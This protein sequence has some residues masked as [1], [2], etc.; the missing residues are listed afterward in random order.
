MRVLLSTIGS[1]GDVEPMVALGRYLRECG[2][3]ALLCAPPGFDQHVGGLAYL[4]IGHDLRHGP[5]RVPG[6]AAATAAAH[7]A[8][9]G[10][11]AEGCDAIVGC[12]AM[13]IAGRSI[14][15]QRG[16]RYHY[17]AYAPVALPSMHHPPPPVGGPPRPAGLDHQSMW[18]LDAQW[19]N[20]TWLSGLNT[21]RGRLGLAP[22]DDVRGHILTARPLLA[23]DPTLAPCP[24]DI[25]TQV[26]QTGAWL[27]TDERPLDR[28]LQAFLDS[29]EPPVLFGF[30]SMREPRV[31]VPVLLGAAREVGR[32]AII[33]R[34]WAGL[35]VPDASP[36]HLSIGETN[37]PALLGRV[38]AIVHHGGAGTTTQ[39]MRAGVPQVIVAHYFDQPYHAERVTALGIG[40]AHPPGAVSIE[41]LAGALQSVLAD[42]VRARA[43]SMAG[44]VRTD[45]IAVAAREIVN[46]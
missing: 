25:A 44:T 27:A 19:W 31:G 39:A 7:F 22:V 9:I 11:A 13:Q 24:A 10:A 46:G 16:L 34:G 41:S 36:E 26:V 18:D 3:D 17:A 14:A 29:G 5:R 12:A 6:G 21:Q 30:G 8:V 28:A 37:L 40:T 20:D 32:R 15:E 45:G 43:A 4:R 23:A 33:L 1:R 42:R 38:A 2:H 35:A